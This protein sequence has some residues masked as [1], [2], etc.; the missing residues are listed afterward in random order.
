MTFRQV[1]E[2]HPY[3]IDLGYDMH[4]RFSNLSTAAATGRHTGAMIRCETS[5]NLYTA[6]DAERI[7]FETVGRFQTNAASI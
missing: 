5:G 3:R 7:F 4:V 2:K 6:N 1:Q